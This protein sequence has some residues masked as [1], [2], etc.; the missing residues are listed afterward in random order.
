MLKIK[1]LPHINHQG[2][3]Y[4]IVASCD[5]ATYYLMK[6]LDVS[7][8][9]L[10]SLPTKWEVQGGLSAYCGSPLVLFP[11]NKLRCSSALTKKS[12][13]QKDAWFLSCKILHTPAGTWFPKSGSNK[14]C[15]R[16]PSKRRIYLPV[17]WRL[18]TVACPPAVCRT[19]G[20]VTRMRFLRDRKMLQEILMNWL[21]AK[22]GCCRSSN[23]EFWWIS[24]CFQGPHLFHQ[25]YWVTHPEVKIE[26]K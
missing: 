11:Q 22:A 24:V 6:A 16:V 15:F 2:R 10:T 12:A 3:I 9:H 14:S 23:T 7:S 13:K 8:V 26:N 20:V 19:R 25:T 17:S 18:I 21:A 1:T 4:T 5:F